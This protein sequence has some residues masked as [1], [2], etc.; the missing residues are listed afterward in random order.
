M[1]VF[2]NIHTIDRVYVQF[3]VTVLGG[4]QSFV[5]LHNFFGKYHEN[6]L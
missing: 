5:V 4:I 3:S 1:N 6:I 2:Y